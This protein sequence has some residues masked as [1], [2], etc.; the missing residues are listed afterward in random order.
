M[1]RE[2]FQPYSDVLPTRSGRLSVTVENEF[3]TGP[4]WERDGSTWRHD[5]TG[6]QRV[7]IEGEKELLKPIL[8]AAQNAL[9]ELKQ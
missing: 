1:V 2:G 8:A 6:R 3:Y 4:D 7:V 5:L 9:E